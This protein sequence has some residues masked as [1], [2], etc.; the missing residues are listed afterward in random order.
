MHKVLFMES[1]QYLQ[2]KFLVLMIMFELPGIP[3]GDYH[4]RT[5]SGIGDVLMKIMWQHTI[6]TCMNALM[7]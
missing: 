7:H 1:I 4:S 2:E 6:N 5:C 3:G